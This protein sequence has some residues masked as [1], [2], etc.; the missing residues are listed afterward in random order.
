MHIESNAITQAQLKTI[1]TLTPQPANLREADLYR[2][3]LCEATN[4]FA[5][6]VDG[7]STR[8]D[9]LYAVRHD[10]C[11]MIKAGCYWDTLDAFE[12][13]VVEKNRTQ[14][15]AACAFIRAVFPLEAK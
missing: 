13:V 7:M 12:A 6:Y 4:V 2:A 5:L 15:I 1:V 14:Y 8:G 10:T 9:Y 11:V 3:N